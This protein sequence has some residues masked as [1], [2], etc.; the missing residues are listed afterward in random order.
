M[1]QRVAKPFYLLLVIV[2]MIQP[3]QS[4]FA[5]SSMSSMEMPAVA[6]DAE[7]SCVYHVVSDD[8]GPAHHSANSGDHAALDDCCSTPACH[9][10]G[11]ISFVPVLRPAVAHSQPRFETSMQGITLPADRK[12]PRSSHA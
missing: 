5:M 2:I 1:N 9:A 12:P 6:A 4:A 10:V 8:A 7:V 11:I 3:L